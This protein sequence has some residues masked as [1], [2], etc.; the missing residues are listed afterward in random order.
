M[1]LRI[2][3]VPSLDQPHAMRTLAQRTKDK[4]E[5]SPDREQYAHLLERL[6]AVLGKKQT[7]EQTA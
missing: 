3:L 6:D 7:E 1:K 5:R 4:I 2:K